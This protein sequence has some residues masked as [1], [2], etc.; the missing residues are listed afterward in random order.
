MAAIPARSPRW[1]E[2][3]NITPAA[4]FQALDSD[5]DTLEAAV[6]TYQASHAELSDK[7]DRV[8]ARLLGLALSL[9]GASFTFAATI[10]VGHH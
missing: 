8:N 2:R 3:R 5:V 6:S 1:I 9:L 10:F 4:H 7:L